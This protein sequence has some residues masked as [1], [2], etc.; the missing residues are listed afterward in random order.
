MLPVLTYRID[1]SSFCSRKFLLH[2]LAFY[3]LCGT[4][5]GILV[6]Y[7]SDP[8]LFYLIRLAI[9]SRVSIV[10][11]SFIILLPFLITAVIIYMSKPFYF[12]ALSFFKAFTFS[13]TITFIHLVFGTYGYLISAVYLLP[14]AVVLLLLHVYWVRNLIGSH[15]TAIKDLLLCSAISIAF[16]VIHTNIFSPTL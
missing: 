3:S 12:I 15:T 9:C 11:L 10:D 13:L 6:A 4:S 5:L 2:L 16:A 8:A 1:P 14:C 7:Q